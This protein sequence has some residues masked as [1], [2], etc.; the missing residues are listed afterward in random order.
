MGDLGFSLL[1]LVLTPAV[2]ITSQYYITAVLRGGDIIEA[3][4]T[5][6]TPTVMPNAEPNTRTA[7]SKL[8]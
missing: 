7:I 5:K 4:T 1:S 6:P 3:I 2:N 8:L